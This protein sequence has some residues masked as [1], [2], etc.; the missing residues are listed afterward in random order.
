MNTANAK[1]WLY[2]T[3]CVLGLGCLAFG[4][5]QL[6]Y[7]QTVSAGTRALQHERFDSQ[8][9]ARARRFWLAREDVLL[10][11]QGL[12]AYRAKNLP[13]AARYFRQASQQTTSPALRTHA[14]Y[15]LGLVMLA[16]DN[17]KDAAELFKEA[18]RLDPDDKQ[19][20]FNLE[21]L[22][23]VV[24]QSQEE[25]GEA[26]LEQ[27]PGTNRDGEDNPHGRD[28]GRSSRESGI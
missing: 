19:A 4:W 2:S 16:L 9:F 6:R 14:L 22:Y 21:R 1:R 10:F 3:A 15:N 25:H 5:Y 20:K 23:H 11:N 18:L 27:A 28:R 12:Q 13:R 24:L 26:A 8:D 7:T 17:A